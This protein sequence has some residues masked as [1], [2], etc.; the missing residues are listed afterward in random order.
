MHDRALDVTATAEALTRYRGRGRMWSRVGA[1]LAA[2]GVVIGIAGA[3]RG[4]GWPA[5]LMSYLVS[6]SAFALVVGA[7]NRQLSGRMRRRLEGG[8]WR[9]CA[10]EAVPRGMHAAAVVLRDPDSGALLP[11]TVLAVQQ[12]F[13][14][15]RPGLSGVLW[16]CG[17]PRNGGVVSP[18]GGGELIWAKPVR[19]RRGRLR[20]VRLAEAKG[21]SQR[22]APRQ[23][24]PSSAPVPF[25]LPLPVQKPI[26]RWGLFR[27]LVL[28][29]AAALALG[30]AG[31]H[32]SDMDPQIDLAVL[33]EQPDGTCQVRWTDPWSGAKREG[34]FHCDPDRDPLLYDWWTGFVVSYGPWKGDLYDA[35]WRGTVANDA[36]IWASDGG[37]ALV[38]VGLAGGGISRWR[39]RGADEAAPTADLVRR[40]VPVS[41][42]K[43]S[44]AEAPVTL[45]FAALATEARR[46]HIPQ[47]LRPGR[48]Y[49]PERDIREVPWWRVRT[50]RNASY[51]TG[52]VANL[53]LA[54]LFGALYWVRPGG[55][56][57]KYVGVTGFALAAGLYS[58]HRL[59]TRGLP[60]A[61]KLARAAL[62]P[63]PV[64]KRYVLLHDP[65][66]GGPVLLFF[67]AHGGDDDLPEAVLPVNSPGPAKRPWIGLPTAATGEAELRGW[68]D[69]DP[70]LVVAW[71]EG[72]ALWPQEPYREINPRDA[73]TRAYL[74]RLAPAG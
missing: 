74:E 28:L 39:R 57:L 29:G 69:N 2:G 7:A 27:W 10:A 63:V 36:N 65:H 17:D 19:G 60:T 67:S 55:D 16:W 8:P 61:R 35:E 48:L 6:A 68:L 58:L 4:L 3:D 13:P 47:T 1:A 30:I 71:I 62:A 34:P 14:L 70:V 37:R 25:G 12:R 32:A 51:L 49:R 59:L 43:A 23:P 26:R 31:D 64:P 5:Q 21:L 40:P 45:A 72:R 56:T 44:D 66:G 54:A 52:T 33:S 11:L 42:V 18:P 38:V 53:G 50:L 20:L 24:Q 15:V 9:A 46:R 22:T 73:G 41:L